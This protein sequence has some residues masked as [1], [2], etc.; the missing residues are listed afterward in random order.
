MNRFSTL[1]FG[2]LATFATSWIGLVLIPAYQIGNLQPVEDA[3]TGDLNPPAQSGLSQHGSVVYAANGCAQCHTQVVR[4]ANS[5]SEIEREWGARQTVARDFIYDKHPQMGV[6]RLGPDLASMAKRFPVASDLHTLLY[7]PAMKN[8]LSKMPS[9][10]FLY[11]TRKIQGEVSA[12]A[13]KLD[14]PYAPKAGFEVVP[15]DEAKALVAYLLSLNRNYGLPEA[16]V[17]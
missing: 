4:S 9:Y 3:A 12:E 2:I 5:G 14:P 15:T 8:G 6:L 17:K 1:F 16:P 7:A 13:L 10:S 11:E